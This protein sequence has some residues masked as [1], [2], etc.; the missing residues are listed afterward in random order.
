[1]DEY[2]YEIS[3]GMPVYGVEKYIERALMSVLNQTFQ[4]IEIILVDDKGIDKSIEIARAIK[5]RHPRGENIKIITHENNMGCW[6]ARNT[7]LREAKGKYLYLMDSDDYI[8]QDCIEKLHTEAINNKSDAVYGS[9]E[10]INENPKID[11]II[12][13]LPNIVIS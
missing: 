6:A 7:I 12:F 3:V 10:Q 5:N 4:D 2:Q 11:H 1:M 8:S 13:S 9:I